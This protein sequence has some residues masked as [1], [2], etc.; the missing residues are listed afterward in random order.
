MSDRKRGEA[1]RE[2]IE[3]ERAY[4]EDITKWGEVFQKRI[5]QSPNLMTLEK[6]V[7]CKNVFINSH[8]IL[9]MHRRIL[10]DLEKKTECSTS[11]DLEYY[12]VFVR[13][14]A[15]IQDVYT[16]Y[17]KSLPKAKSVL[18]H[19][20]SL[21]ED[22]E[23]LITKFLTENSTAGDYMHYLYRPSQ[24][25][26]RYWLLLKAVAKHETDEVCQRDAEALLVR[27]NEI[28]AEIDSVYGCFQNHFRVFEISKSLR[29]G[30]FYKPRGSLNLFFKGRKVVKEGDI[31]S[32]YSRLK[33]PQKQRVIV[34]DHLLLVCDV[35]AQPQ[36]ET[37]YL[38]ETFA[39]YKF[40]ITTEHPVKKVASKPFSVYIVERNGSGF[41]GLFFENR[42]ECD[43][44]TAALQSVAKQFSDKYD[45]RIA[46]TELGDVSEE[47]ISYAC[48]SFAP[49]DKK[50]L[51]RT[52]SFRACSSI[53]QTGS[54]QG[55]DP[56]L[57]SDVVP[58]ENFPQAKGIIERMLFGGNIFGDRVRVKRFPMHEDNKNL[59]LFGTKSGVFER[60]YGRN[61]RLYPRA[62]KKFI[63]IAD[64][65]LLILLDSMR[66]LVSSFNVATLNL[67]IQTLC[68]DAE[69]FFYIQTATTRFIVVKKN[70]LEAF[71][72][73]FL[74]AVEEEN[75]C[76]K[77]SMFQKLSIGSNV[78]SVRFFDGEIAVA[79]NSFTWISPYSLVTREVV[80]LLDPYVPH[81]FLLC[82]ESNALSIYQV[83]QTHFLVCFDILGFIINKKGAAAD[84]HIV[85]SWDCIPH[86]IRI[87]GNYIVVLGPSSSAVFSMGSGALLFFDSTRTLR[88]C[89]GNS[90]I[91]HDGHAFYTFILPQ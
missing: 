53:V 29:R 88:F 2:V 6:H 32:F 66:V 24:K 23:I 89:S 67:D 79:A 56:E 52:S 58:E 16:T 63:F 40:D 22:F 83:S 69:N 77:I 8:E 18:S 72:F 91:M 45:K 55:V 36:E 61:Q 80:S 7:F 49:I 14:L 74:Y 35:F 28:I 54:G 9:D 20:I 27:F 76:F 87:F 43:V 73:L 78:Q 86:D 26:T 31:L 68:S 37:L 90:R 39:P 11:D 81:Y 15:E 85:F 62:C 13:Y 4:V 51:I 30:G 19:E 48:E 60:I 44:W 65:S 17:V 75:D 38:Q 33:M 42:Q 1:L 12:S 25:V 10:A 3:S 50:Q 84:S 64:L 82:Q 71:C 59:I 21:S 5:K 47:E 57:Y 41:L 34:F 70:S 46:I